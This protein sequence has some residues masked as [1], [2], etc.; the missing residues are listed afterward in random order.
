MS[1]IKISCPHCHQRLGIPEAA[2]GRTILC[3]LCGGR[4]G[5]PAKPESPPVAAAAESAPEGLRVIG[6]GL[7]QQKTDIKFSCPNCDVH[8]VISDRAAGKKI[9]CQ[10]CKA[11]ILVPAQSPASAPLPPAAAPAPAPAAAAPAFTAPP[12]APAPAAAPAFQAAPPPPA[13]APAPE[14]AAA[15]AG[16]GQV[17]DL[18]QRL[19]N[20]DMQ[21]GRALIMFGQN[22]LPTL[23]DGFEEN[24]LEEPDTNR[25]ADHIVNLLAKCGGASVPPLIAKLGKC[26]HA[27]YG[28]GKIG[29]DEAIQALVRE[30]S[31]VNWRRVEIA[32]KALSMVATPNVLK[33]VGQIETVRRT[34]R[35]GEVYTAAG[36]ALVEIQKRFPSEAKAAPAMQTA[37]IV[38][39]NS[40]LKPA[41]PLRPARA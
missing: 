18:I 38:A 40:P 11:S 2:L 26:R 34:T 4:I 29:N 39:G 22:I 12:P 15:P 8:I 17:P 25:G 27:Y 19:R 33:V 1:D 31:S 3:P 14:P 10:R 20:G 37:K 9:V 35:V 28:L 5:L 36:N 6:V 7:Q 21:A 30:L 24:S 23:V 41:I 13:P 16:Q 32:C